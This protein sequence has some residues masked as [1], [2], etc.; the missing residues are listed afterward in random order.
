MNVS[1]FTKKILVAGFYLLTIFSTIAGGLIDRGRVKLGDVIQP[2]LSP[3]SGNVSYKVPRH[4][5]PSSTSRG[6]G[7]TS[8]TI[9]EAMHPNGISIGHIPGVGFAQEQPWKKSLENPVT[10]NVEFKALVKAPINSPVT[11]SINGVSVSVT[12]AGPESE[13]VSESGTV[14]LQSHREY[15]IAFNGDVHDVRIE[16]TE[17]YLYSSSGTGLRQNRGAI[18][19]TTYINDNQRKTAY[20]N[21]GETAG[22][23]QERLRLSVRPAEQFLFEDYPD[24]EETDVPGDGGWLT[25]GPGKDD[26]VRDIAF[27][28]DCF[29]GRKINGKSGGMIRLREKGINDSSYTPEALIFTHSTTNEFDV[30]AITE[31]NGILKQVWTIQALANVVSNEFSTEIEFYLPSEFS[32]D[33]DVTGLFTNITGSPYVTWEISNPAQNHSSLDELWLTETR[34]ALSYT[35]ILSFNDST[36]TWT[37]TKGGSSDS[38]IIEKREIS[39]ENGIRIEEHTIED[40]A[41]VKSYHAVEK[42][43]QHVLT[44]DLIE[45]TTDPDGAD[46]QTTTLAYYDKP[47]DGSLFGMFKH[48]INPDGTWEKR[49]YSGFF[50][51]VLRPFQNSPAHPNDATVM[52]SWLAHTD[53]QEVGDYTGT[54]TFNY[55]KPNGVVGG[56]TSATYRQ[57]MIRTGGKVVSFWEE[58]GYGQSYPYKEDAV[59]TRSAEDWL[60]GMPVF[61]VAEM[62]DHFRFYY[63]LVE[64]NTTNGLYEAIDIANAPTNM[65]DEALLCRVYNLNATEFN[66]GSQ[67]LY[68]PEYWTNS[69]SDAVYLLDKFLGK[70][71][72]ESANTPVG[73]AVYPNRN[74]YTESIFENGLKVRER[75]YLITG[76]SDHD[77]STSVLLTEQFFERNE[78]GLLTNSYSLDPVTSVYRTNYMAS[79][80]GT[81]KQWHVDEKA[82]KTVYEYDGLKRVSKETLKGIVHVEYDDIPDEVVDRAYNAS[83]NL[84]ASQV[85]TGIFTNGTSLSYDLSGRMLM[86]TNVDGTTTYTYDGLVTRKDYPGGWEETEKYLDGTPYSKR[87]S[88]MVDEYYDFIVIPDDSPDF[89]SSY[90]ITYYGHW[91]SPRWKRDYYEAANGPKP[92]SEEKPS[93]GGGTILSQSL[94]YRDFSLVKTGEET[95][96]MGTKWVEEDLLRRITTIETAPYRKSRVEVNY[97]SDGTSWFTAK[98]QSVN[99]LTNGEQYEVIEEKWKRVNG[100]T[101]NLVSEE[102]VFSDF[103]EDSTNR[104]FLSFVDLI[105]TEEIYSQ[106]KA[107]G[108]TN[109]YVGNLLVE[110]H[111]GGILGS[112]KMSYD[113]LG[114][115]TFLEFPDGRSGGKTYEGTSQRVKTSF[116]EMG[117][118]TTYEYF[119]EDGVVKNKI[120]STSLSDG[121]TTFYGYDQNGNQTSTWGSAGLPQRKEFDQYGQLVALS[122]YRN[123]FGWEAE[124][125]P[126]NTTGAADRIEWDFDEFSGVLLEK[127]DAAQEGVT[128]AYGDY[129]E[130]LYITNARMAV[131]TNVYDLSTADLIRVDYPDRISDEYKEFNAIGLPQ[132]IEGAFGAFSIGYNPSGVQTSYSD[133]D[134]ISNTNSYDTAGRLTNMVFSLNG[135]NFQNIVYEYDSQRGVLNSIFDGDSKASYSWSDTNANVVGLEFVKGQNPIM[136]VWR[137]YTTNSLLAAITVTNA[138]GVLSQN[139]YEYFL[140][141]AIKKFTSHGGKNWNYAY[142]S[143]FQLTSAVRENASAEIIPGHQLDFGYDNSGNRTFRSQG[144][145]GIEGV[146]Q[147]LTVDHNN[148]ISLIKNEGGALFF[149][150]CATNALVTINGDVATRVG[151]TWAWQSGSEP[152]VS[153]SILE[154]TNIVAGIGEGTNGVDLAEV[155]N[156][157]IWVDPPEEIL[158]WDQDGN[159]VENGAFTFSWSSYNRLMEIETKGGF[160]QDELRTLKKFIYDWDGRKIYSTNFI[161]N[162][163]SN[164]FQINKIERYVYDG[165]LNVATLVKTNSSQSFALDTKRV[166]GVDVTGAMGGGNGGV[167]GLLWVEDAA[168]AETHF[169]TSD[170]NGNI[171]GFYLGEDVGYLPIDYSPYGHELFDAAF[172]SVVGGRKFSSQEAD[173]GLLAF[174]YRHFSTRL[175]RWLNRDPL[176]EEGGLNLYGFVDNNPISSFDKLGNSLVTILPNPGDLSNRGRQAAQNNAAKNRIHDMVEA[177]ED[178]SEI[179]GLVLDCTTGDAT[180]LVMMLKSADNNPMAGGHR[181][182]KW[183]NSRTG[184]DNHHLLPN[185]MKDAFDAM[186]LDVDRFMVGIE[187]SIHRKKIHGRRKYGPGGIWNAAWKEFMGWDGK[188]FKK[189]RSKDEVFEFADKLLGVFL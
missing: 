22:E 122:T 79:W 32:P 176:A 36:D 126:T 179:V 34:G 173:S 174:K 70:D 163:S 105:K 92:N 17:V 134:G 111:V 154:T 130:L 139:Q 170:S 121:R 99:V 131:V 153:R 21:V 68:A 177:Y 146:S 81:L 123:G 7:F 164:V 88:G 178:I 141:K 69:S 151:N 4:L 16:L 132:R 46:P 39:F 45:V 48:Q 186:G 19:Y 13:V 54:A 109:I 24:P 107:L 184:F 143:R 60:I 89:D 187:R 50:S 8:V 108:D 156:E 117:L 140:N 175:G 66:K 127:R 57:P 40:Q 78:L 37:L 5:H 82:R 188:K 65:V 64:F 38:Q 183:T 98:I 182:K 96:E 61:S 112:I 43:K 118:I 124:I 157:K 145:G 49:S 110:S 125:W 129:L 166:W 149:G 181:K 167:G 76:V 14:E 71:L 86:S 128:Y 41:N 93:V 80:S 90:K 119:D 1:Q 160:V 115:R 31:T 28:W 114:R 44:W 27:R 75:N 138:G 47:T 162:S 12:G 29:V 87:G 100:F 55:Y 135:T 51:G 185:Q 58:Y 159:L 35:N 73:P 18:S 168:T 148:A 26:N 103:D 23:V 158:R 25:M 147:K 83:G 150:E 165:N 84:I 15:G 10:V 72:G 20:A 101:T 85:V 9:G 189:K 67:D 91:G 94:Q 104:T 180:D 42:Y 155:N 102:W 116:G 95:F 144:G 30:I 59:Y 53:Y 11:V 3:T 142:D 74:T 33:Q 137:S 97:V 136:D 120:K 62:K 171:S 56:A 113:D 63:D 133:G 161:W 172:S 152:N 6:G 2:K 52:N 77:V 106:N 169:P